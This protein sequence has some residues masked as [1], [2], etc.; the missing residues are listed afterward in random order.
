MSERCFA[1]IL[2]P[3]H[4]V[5]EEVAQ[6][7]KEYQFE[8]EYEEEGVL[9]LAACHAR[10]GEYA[11]LET[12]L[13]KKEIP[14]TRET[15]SY[16]GNPARIAHYRPESG[17]EVVECYVT[18]DDGSHYVTTDKLRLLLD[19]RPYQAMK[20]LKALLDEHAPEVKPLEDYVPRETQNT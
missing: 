5:D 19:L 4:L 6:E 8:T 15:E 14:Y 20:E 13:R 10:N 3:E 9:Y 17:D 18:D 11:D 2:I 16:L 7:I 1:Q 12:M